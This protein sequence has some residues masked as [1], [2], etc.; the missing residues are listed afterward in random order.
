ME[1][2]GLLDLGAQILIR[3]S[4]SLEEMWSRLSVTE[5]EQSDVLVE[6]ELEDASA[7]SKRSLSTGKTSYMEAG[8]NESD[9]DSFHE[10][11]EN[12]IK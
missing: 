12:F 6:K 10:D 11:M 5:E 1:C 2:F 9:E 4:E 7:I 8:E 3:M